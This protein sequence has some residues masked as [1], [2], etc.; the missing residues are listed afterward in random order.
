MRGSHSFDLALA[1]VML[2][3]AVSYSAAELPKTTDAPAQTAPNSLVDPLERET[4]RSAIIGLLKSEEREDYANAARY[5]QPTPGQ[6][7]NLGE[8]AKEF[9]ALQ[10][11]FK[12]NPGLLSADPNGTVEL[13]LPLGQVRAGAWAVGE[14]TADVILVRVD[15]PAYGKI[16]LISKETVASI[17]KLYSLMRSETPASTAPEASPDALREKNSQAPGRK[18]QTHLRRVAS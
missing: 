10:P 14:T 6:N 16:W 11:R 2:A 12:S 4:P 9:R 5:L 17:P 18:A 7:I 13:G 15:D 1:V 3:G 8:R